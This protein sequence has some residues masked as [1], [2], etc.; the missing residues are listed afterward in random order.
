MDQKSINWKSVFTFSLLTYKARNLGVIMDYDQNLHS[1]SKFFI[2]TAY[3]Q[4]KYRQ[5]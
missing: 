3:D 5:S 1:R 4:I 2:K